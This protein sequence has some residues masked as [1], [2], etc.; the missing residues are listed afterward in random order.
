MALLDGLVPPS[1]TYSSTGEPPSELGADHDRVAM[2]LPGVTVS[3][4]GA[5]GTVGVP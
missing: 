2:P 4:V 5:P 1:M 3:P